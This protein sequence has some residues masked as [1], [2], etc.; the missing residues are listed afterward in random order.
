MAKASEASADVLAVLLADI[1]SSGRPLS[2]AQLLDRGRELVEKN[3]AGD[4]ALQS[5]LYVNLAWRYQILRQHDR[6]LALRALGEQAARRAGDAN[7]L[8]SALCAGVGA[9]IDAG[10]ATAAQSRVDEARRVLGT[11]TAA[12]RL[13]VSQACLNAEAELANDRREHELAVRLSQQA[14]KLFEDAD[15]RESPAY[16]AALD[17]LAFRHHNAG[18]PHRAFEVLQKLG[19]A[20]DA[21]GRTHT[22]ERLQIMANTGISLVQFGEILPAGAV[23][24]EA[25]KRSQ[26]LDLSVPSTDS[27]LARIYGTG[28]FLLGRDAEA[29][30][31]LTYAHKKA[32]EQGATYFQVEAGGYLA[33]MLVRAARFDE[34]DVALNGLDAALPADVGKFSALRAGIART[35]AELALQR[36]DVATAQRQLEPS[37]QRLGPG[38]GSARDRV[39]LLPLA[40][41]VALAAGALD[42]AKAHAESFMQA[43]LSQAR[44]PEQSANVGQAWQLLGDVQQRQGLKREALASRQRALPILVAALGP[45]HPETKQLQ[46]LLARPP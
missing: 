8:A 25:V 4:P 15:A 12:P 34:A 13:V 44:L 2:P 35:R 19:Q 14:V 10:R 31:W 28:L 33:R 46:A 7:G 3:Y 36:G 22:R 45:E 5:E 21:N 24:Q 16:T 23:F 6:E 39:T 41:G 37:F 17:N 1:G 26:G 18:Q 9:D 30:L 43:A 27:D 32:R 11:M 29:T 20:M 40:T 38:G 42:L